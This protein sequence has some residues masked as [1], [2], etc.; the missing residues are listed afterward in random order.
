MSALFGFE[1]V[2]VAISRLDYIAELRIIAASFLRFNYVCG[3]TTRNTSEGRDII[4]LD[5]AK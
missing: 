5:D 2:A 3:A 4:P 1:R